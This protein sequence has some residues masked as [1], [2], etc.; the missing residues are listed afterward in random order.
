MKKGSFVPLLSRISY[1]LVG[2]CCV[3]APYLGEGEFPRVLEPV[4]VGALADR[5][6]A[7][8]LRV[9]CNTGTLAALLLAL[10]TLA[11]TKPGADMFPDPIV[12]TGKGIEIKRSTVEDGFVTEKTIAM[13]QQ[14]TTIPDSERPRLESDI[15]QHM[16]VD[17]IL[18]QQA[19]AEEKTRT[20][21]QVDKYIAELRT[22]AGSDDRFQLQVKASGKTLDE[23]KAGDYEKELARLVMLRELVPT[24]AVTPDLVRKFYDDPANATNFALP[25]TVHVAH[26]LISVI[27]PATRQPLPP[28][29]I[30]EKEKLAQDIKAQA[31]KGADFG[32]LV[33]KYSDDLSTTNSGGELRFARHTL[34][35]AFAGFEGA[36]F[37]LKTNQVSDPV[38]SPYGFHLIKMLDKTPASTADFSKVADGIRDYLIGVE[39]NKKLPAFVPK[40]FEQYNVKIT[41]PNY[42]PTPLTA[43]TNTPTN[44]M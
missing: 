24:N 17:K 6:F 9:L 28:A 8:V 16:I 10:P 1:S 18:V 4:T 36:A 19:T 38:E 42:A 12:A 26:I 40:L 7:A 20:H 11:Q 5:I 15:L 22:A 44:R 29:K 21:D 32:D 33:R 23:I 41:Y 39:L 43:P 13:Q 34:G 27:D 37:S 31:E 30:R 25:E 2:R 35:A 3:A 14:H